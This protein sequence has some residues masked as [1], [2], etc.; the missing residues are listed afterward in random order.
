MPLNYDKF[1]FL[2][3]GLT[4]PRPVPLNKG[5]FHSKG[6]Q[7]TDEWLDFLKDTLIPDLYD[8][9][10][11]ATAED[12]ERGV[13][14]IEGEEDIDKG[15]ALW[16]RDTLIPDL[17][18][19]GYS[20]TA[21]DFHDLAWHIERAKITPFPRR[22]PAGRVLVLEPG[23]IYKAK[24]FPAGLIADMTRPGPVDDAATRWVNSRRVR[25]DAVNAMRIY[26]KEE[27]AWS[28][29]ELQVYEHNL[30]RLLWL[31]AGDIK[32]YGEWYFGR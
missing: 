30:A 2:D 11:D 5:T 27:G 20:E 14:M 17:L 31:A 4:V 9:G 8:S 12:F 10:K 19:S 23:N 16:L 1:Q 28:D 25:V 24:D 7:S 26:L 29:S 3:H 6:K 21:K 22:N 18:E 13:R 32:E 15:F